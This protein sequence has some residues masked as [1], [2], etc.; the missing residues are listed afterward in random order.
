MEKLILFLKCLAD[1]NRLMILRLLMEDCFCVCD[2]Q[3]LTGKSQSSISQHLSYFK[4]L[5][6]LNHK[7]IKKKTCYA[8]DRKVYNKYLSNLIS[9]NCI[10]LDDFNLEIFSCDIKNLDLSQVK[11]KRS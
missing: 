6:L 7:K 11:N 1:E 4:E 3:E 9:L 2:L 8:L 5:G 10:S